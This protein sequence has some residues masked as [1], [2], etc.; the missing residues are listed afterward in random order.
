MA[1]STS[2][3]SNSDRI[4]EWQTKFIDVSYKAGSGNSSSAEIIDILSDYSW[5]ADE[6][7]E[8]NENSD[9]NS[10]SKKNNLPFCYI[11]ERKSA[12]NAGIAN[13]INML[14]SI[15]EMGD[16]S[17]DAINN[18]TKTL[19]G[20]TFLETVGQKGTDAIK[21]ISDKIKG[22]LNSIIGNSKFN[23][24]LKANNL[25]D[26]DLLSPYRYL[27]ITKETNKRYVMPLASDGSNDI[28]VSN[29]WGTPQML[30][31]FLQNFADIGFEL[32]DTASRSC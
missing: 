3:L 19:A 10:Y 18:T 24:L 11:I 17:L 31:G 28:N 1:S 13:I 21:S 25:N 2:S 6:I 8:K 29:K 27:Y 12:A 32:I 15:T 16:K 20:G 22:T 4:K 30:P 7:I 26:G 23:E 9:K 14:S 5:I